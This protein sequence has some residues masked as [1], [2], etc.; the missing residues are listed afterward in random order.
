VRAVRIPTS[1]VRAVNRWVGPILAWLEMLSGPRWREIAEHTRLVGLLCLYLAIVLVLPLPFV[2][3]V[4][5]ICLAAVALGLLRHDGL[6][7]LL[8]LAGTMLLTAALVYSAIFATN[9]LQVIF[10]R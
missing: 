9:L 1:V 3:L 10:V 8:G 5:A 2:N 6:F 4:P 7:V